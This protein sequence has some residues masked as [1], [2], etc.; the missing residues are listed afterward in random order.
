MRGCS[1]QEW[2]LIYEV[3]DL[4]LVDCAGIMESMQKQL[5][6]SKTIRWLILLGLIAIVLSA[7]TNGGTPVSEET[8]SP[9]IQES[10]STTIPQTPSATPPPS[11]AIVNGER[12]PLAFFESEVQRYLIAQQSS[13]QL[14]EDDAAVREIVLNDLIDQV[15]L[16]QGAREAGI[17]ITDAAVQA[18][19]DELASEVDLADWMSEWGY[20]DTDLFDSLKLQMEAAG[21]RDRIAAEIPDMVEQVEL[22][23]VFAYTE[24]GANSARV[25]LNSGRDFEEVALVYDPVTGG[26]LG[27]VPRGYLLIP[28]VET[29]AFDLQVGEYSEIIESE[30]GYHIVMV[31]DRAE[32]A[33][34]QDAKLTLQRKALQDWVADQRGIAIIEVLI[35]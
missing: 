10:T 17:T 27:W 26:Y 12:I 35:D 30:I 16:A 25:S 31:L 33:L 32:R 24:E 19:L 18:R 6:T 5:R 7:C 1:D 15:L 20:S 3:L 29:A 28:A 13:G 8:A 2:P 4:R 34:S 11:A 21:Q 14:I 23:Q 22:R 9:T